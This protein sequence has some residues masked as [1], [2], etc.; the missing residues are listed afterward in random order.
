MT[1]NLAYHPRNAF[2][3]LVNGEMIFWGI[4][5]SHKI[6]S[7]HQYS[8]EI[9]K[10]NPASKERKI[11]F[12]YPENSGSMHNWKSITRP[13]NN[14]IVL[15]GDSSLFQGY[16]TPMFFFISTSFLTISRNAGLDWETIALDTNKVFLDISMSDSLN[17]VI[18]EATTYNIFNWHSYSSTNDSL[19]IT[20]DSWKSFRRISMPPILP[21][22]LANTRVLTFKAGQIIL[23]KDKRMIISNDTGNT[24]LSKTICDTN[25]FIG[26]NGDPPRIKANSPENIVICGYKIPLGFPNKKV[27]YLAV[28]TDTGTTWKKYFLNSEFEEINDVDY[29][30]DSCAIAVCN[31]GRILRTKDNWKTWLEDEISDSLDSKLAYNLNLSPLTHVEYIDESNALAFY[32]S[33]YFLNFNNGRQTLVRPQFIFDSLFSPIDI[34]VDQTNS[35]QIRWTKVEG[36]IKYRLLIKKIDADSAITFNEPDID[37]LISTNEYLYKNLEYYKKYI[38]WIKAIGNSIES[39]WNYQKPLFNTAKKISIYPPNILYPKNNDTITTESVTFIWNENPLAD[40]YNIKVT[41]LK[42]NKI[43]IQITTHDTIL[44]YQLLDHSSAYKL[45]IASVLYVSEYP[46]FELSKWKEC[47][48]YIKDGTAVEHDNVTG[49]IRIIPNPSFDYIDIL[50]DHRYDNQSEKLN[51]V[52]CNLLGASIYQTQIE[53]SE[54]IRVSLPKLSPGMYFVKIG[55][56]HI[57]FLKE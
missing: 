7:I 15:A 23:F 11:L 9:I 45:Q 49:S 39:Q 47:L 54:K 14:M 55:S 42:T 44:P 52:I 37:T 10:Y 1:T 29:I 33:N 51:I 5:Y 13:C 56:D 26:I 35:Y 27:P 8:N 30:N 32:S 53:N 31:T 25:E 18:V 34:D 20:N 19:L 21:K 38:C 22:E 43:M 24:W 16:S 50:F 17:G 2:T 4:N 46:G 40:S 57:K 48:F 28:T 36:A 12:S 6:D 3:N 41:N